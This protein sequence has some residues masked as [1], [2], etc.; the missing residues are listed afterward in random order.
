[1]YFPES[2]WRDYLSEFVNDVAWMD[3][4]SAVVCT[5]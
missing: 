2:K 4:E 5:V 3:F 1:M